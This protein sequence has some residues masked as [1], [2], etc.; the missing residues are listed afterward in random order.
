M[1]RK[2]RH[3]NHERDRRALQMFLGG[4]EAARIVRYLN[5]PPRRLE[6]LLRAAGVVVKDE[7]AR[8]RE[9]PRPPERPLRL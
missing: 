9:P 8:V 4:V 1:P 3:A 6:R 5:V 2:G 7:G